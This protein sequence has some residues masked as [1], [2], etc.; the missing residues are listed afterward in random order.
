MNRSWP[1]II[2]GLVLLAILVLY[3]VA[4]QV[5]Y[6]EAAIVK[7]FGKATE[8]DVILGEKN[9]GLYF[10]W[11]WPIQN[12]DKYDART[13]ILETH[14]EQTATQ[15]KKPII[16]A[17]FVGWRIANPY[18]FQE[19][20]TGGPE[21]AER[22]LREIIETHQ[23]EVVGQYPFA[24]LVSKDAAELKFDDI[25]K[26]IRDRVHAVAFSQYGIA[27]D[28]VGV[29]RLALPQ[30][31]TEKV[32]AA[33]RKDRENQAQKYISEGESEKKRI[34]SDAKA[35]ADTI[36]YFAENLAQKYRSLGTANA[37]QYYAELQKDE[38][39][40]LFLDRL[41]KLEE[42]LKQRTTIVLTWD[43]YPFS[44]F[45]QQ[46]RLEPAATTRPVAEAAVEVPP[47]GK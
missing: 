41:K 43:Q 39:L 28:C 2:A 36:L 18:R 19:S 3:M 42:I 11:P 4:F 14:T 45:K 44:E 32:F 27:I 30:D 8:Q 13:R 16:V 37:A 9:A 20:L 46:G 21:A 40:A 23:K 5:R 47:G 1:S 29:K 10:K 22:K 24:Q 33:M 34:I 15:D 7:T 25:E 17:T 12:V 35:K 6:T 31:V 26:A 38:P